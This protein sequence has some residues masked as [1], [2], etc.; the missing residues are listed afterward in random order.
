MVVATAAAAAAAVQSMGFSAGIAGKQAKGAC[1]PFMSRLP[2]DGAAT[3][4]QGL[5]PLVSHF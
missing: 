5:L 1:F 2:L 4:S 3:R